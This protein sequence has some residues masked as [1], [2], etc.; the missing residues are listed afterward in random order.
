LATKTRKRH[1]SCCATKTL[2]NE[3]GGLLDVLDDREKKII[4]SASG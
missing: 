4:S 1:S 2:R 3:V